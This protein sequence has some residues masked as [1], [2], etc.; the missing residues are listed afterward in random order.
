MATN[1]NRNGGDMNDDKERARE[2]VALAI[3]GLDPIELTKTVASVIDTIK[4]NANLHNTVAL[5]Q[6]LNYLLQ[7]VPEGPEKEVL[8]DGTTKIVGLDLRGTPGFE[9]GYPWERNDDRRIN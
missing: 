4:Q 9:N 6:V 2:V 7:S 8:I 3:A 1:S 5:A